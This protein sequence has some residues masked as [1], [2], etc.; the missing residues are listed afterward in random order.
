MASPGD[1]SGSRHLP[2]LENKRKRD[3][4][5][6][7]IPNEFEAC[8]F[9][10]LSPETE[11]VGR[12]LANIASQ[13]LET[14]GSRDAVLYGWNA[15]VKAADNSDRA[16]RAEEIRVRDASKLEEASRRAKEAEEVAAQLR[17]ELDA[18]KKAAVDANAAAVKSEEELKEIT[19]LM[20]VGDWANTVLSYANSHER[21]NTQDIDHSFL[22]K[23]LK[24]EG[25]DGADAQKKAKEMAA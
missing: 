15:F 24:K 4:D 9:R 13:M 25:T 22:M 18:S 16:R 21:Q 11:T 3:E 20:E 17:A 23:T 19:F 12:N 8:R 2:I 5:I 14:E 1:G 6:Q 7:N 10:G